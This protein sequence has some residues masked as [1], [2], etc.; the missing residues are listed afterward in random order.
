[1]VM[2]NALVVMDVLVILAGAAASVGVSLNHTNCNN[3]RLTNSCFLEIAN[4]TS[5]G[6]G[7]STSSHP[8]LLHCE[9]EQI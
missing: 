8:D 2:V 6:G 7:G 9:I 1:M 4:F 3:I 5:G